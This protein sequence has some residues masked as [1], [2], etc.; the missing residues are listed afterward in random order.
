MSIANV[1]RHE[2]ISGL[3]L[4]VLDNLFLQPDIEGLARF[5]RA[6]PSTMN[7]TDS[8]EA[9]Y[10]PHWGS[11]LPV[12]MCE[13]KPILKE[14]ISIARTLLAGPDLPLHQVHVNT[15]LY[16]DFQTPHED[17]TGGV[18]AIYFAHPVWKENWMGE[19]IFY[20]ANR[21][22]VVA[23]APK[24]GRLVVFQ[25][26]LLHRGGVPSRECFEPRLSVAFKFGRVARG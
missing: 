26:D 12:A 2:T 21:E 14:C 22:A 6:L 15:H 7:W 9:G 5:C 3:E 13:G 4:F 19:T 23:V 11:E 17:L 20:D 16:G 8:D 24:P 25:A 1:S 18:T 10:A